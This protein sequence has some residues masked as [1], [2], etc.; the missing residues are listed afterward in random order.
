MTKSMTKYTCLFCKNNF[1]AYSSQRNRKKIFCSKKCKSEEQKESL[2]GSNNPN[3][4]YGEDF[5]KFIKN[6][7]GKYNDYVNFCL[8]CHENG[9]N[10]CRSSLTDRIRKLKLNTDHFIYSDINNK[11]VVDLVIKYTKESFSYLEISNKI[12]DSNI[13]RILGR[14]RI[15]EIINELN[16]DISHF[17]PCAIRPQSVEDKFVKGDIRKSVKGRIIKD[18]L[19]EYK[20]L[21][22]GIKDKWNNLKISLELDHINGDPTDN[23]LENLRF[24]CPNCHS[25]TNTYCGLNL[26]KK[27]NKTVL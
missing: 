21:F 13:G 27:K 11:L 3:Y 19:L 8:A 25:Q 16:L 23:R 22:C 12:K 18:N 7:I 6:N 14:K 24:L 2:K 17:K 10:I 1:E 5:N 4:R 20:C 9:F 15:K 26:S